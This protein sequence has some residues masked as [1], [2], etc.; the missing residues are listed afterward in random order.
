MITVPSFI[1]KRLYVKGSMCNCSQGFQF[2][3]RNTLGSGWGNEVFP[4][5]VD[6]KEM[7]KQDSFF[8]VDGE[9]LCFSA[10]C[11]EKPFTLGMNKTITILVRNASLTEGPHKVN[12]AFVAQ[13]LGK[14][15]FEIADIVAA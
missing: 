9:E 6:G 10:V 4:L 12:L 7:P 5:A 3:L 11:K 13:G 14:L 2:E 8:V 1:L 15:G